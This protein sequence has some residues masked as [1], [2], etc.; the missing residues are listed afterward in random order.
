MTKSELKNCKNWT[1]DPDLPGRIQKWHKTLR[2]SMGFTAADVG[3]LC[4]ITRQTVNNIESGKQTSVIT[5]Y[6]IMYILQDVLRISKE[7]SF[8]R[9]PYEI[10]MCLMYDAYE[11]ETEEKKIM[12]IVD[13]KTLACAYFHHVMTCS[14]VDKRIGDIFSDRDTYGKIRQK[15]E[16]AWGGNF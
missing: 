12:F 13:L 11:F 4:G 15:E 16:F 14:E 7:A 6:G 2:Y 1:A 9:L 5:L 10:I 8:S 3:A